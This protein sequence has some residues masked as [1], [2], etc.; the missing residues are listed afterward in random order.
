MYE[1]TQY[2][3]KN[4]ALLS[5]LF[6]FDFSSLYDV[7]AHGLYYLLSFVSAL[8]FHPYKEHIVSDI[9]VSK[10]LED[11]ILTVMNTMIERK[12][13]ISS[14]NLTTIR[15]LVNR[16]LRLQSC[17]YTEREN[18]FFYILGNN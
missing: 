6:H 1:F 16:V 12:L 11:Q 4:H 8:C 7:S 13:V 2:I 17:L 18:Y 10:K 15:S 3:I 14:P 5:Y 9:Q